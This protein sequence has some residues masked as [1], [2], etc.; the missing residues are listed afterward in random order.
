MLLITSIINI[1]SIFAMEEQIKGAINLV[2]GAINLGNNS[3]CFL[4]GPAIFWQSMNLQKEDNDY[5]MSLPNEK[6]RVK[7]S[8]EDKMLTISGKKRKRSKDQLD[9]NIDTKKQKQDLSLDREEGY[10]VPLEIGESIILDNELKIKI[11]YDET[12]KLVSKR[13]HSQYSFLRS[14]WKKKPFNFRGN[15]SSHNE[16]SPA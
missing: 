10:E 4:E 2:K 7:I 16:I 8:A 14:N 6:M 11:T 1:T 5:V 13:D 15:K 12:V 9:D 3:V